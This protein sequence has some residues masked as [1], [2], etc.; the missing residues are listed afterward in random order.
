MKILYL[1]LPGF[2]DSDFPL[3]REY[4]RRGEDVTY[5]LDLI[6]I[7]KRSTIIDIKDIIQENGLIKAARYKELLPYKEYL[8]F[9]K[10]Y[11]LNR[12]SNR[13]Y[14]L[15][16]LS[17]MMDFSNFIKKEKFDVIHCTYPFRAFDTILY[18]FSHKMVMTFHDPFPH[19]GE[20]NFLKEVYRKIAIKMVKRFVLLNQGQKERFIREYCISNDNVLVNQMGVFDYLNIFD[21]SKHDKSFRVLFFGRIS[22]YKGLEYLC[23]AFLKVR[24]QIKNA[25]LIIAGG[26]KI[27][28]DFTPYK[29][30][31]Y[32][33][34]YNKYIDTPSLVEFLSDCAF[35]ICPY[36]DATQS[37]VILTSFS[38]K[39]PVIASNVGALGEMVESEKTGLLV[40]PKDIDALANAI[41]S[42]FKNPDKLSDFENAINKE[43]IHGNKSW[44]VIAQ[45]YIDYYQITTQR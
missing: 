16:S 33:H 41:I 38:L 30:K 8:D 12:T 44:K 23:K 35:T 1:S 25:E 40:E 7:S 6:P 9:D 19:T 28:F 2:A 4:Q 3:V 34:L 26:G 45:K 13:R 5:V 14:S 22:P 43:F 39:K 18:R 42:L 31:K 21:K 29:N 10:F 17:L 36:T 37:G 24:E 11:I 32:I 20:K 15:K 27:Y